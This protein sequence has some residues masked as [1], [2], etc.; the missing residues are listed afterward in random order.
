MAQIQESENG[1]IS[2]QT[3]AVNE[4]EI[5]IKC[6]LVDVWT[7]ADYSSSVSAFSANIFSAVETL[8]RKLLQKEPNPSLNRIVRN[9]AIFFNQTPL[10]VADLTEDQDQFLQEVGE[11]SNKIGTGST[12][13]AY[14]LHK[15]YQ[16]EMSALSNDEMRNHSSSFTKLAILISDGHSERDAALTAA[17]ILKSSGFNIL[18]LIVRAK[19]GGKT[20]EELDSEANP[21]V[22]LMKEISG[23][24]SDY[25]NSLEDAFFA[26]VT[27]QGLDE[28]FRTK[29]TCL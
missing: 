29:F 16:A 1:E 5:W 25:A 26:S 8:G 24:T 17:R 3:G 14:A 21:G 22:K 15:V 19:E 20:L 10:V 18:S 11:H 7:V 28:F 2:I 27:L 6:A 4:S 13:I 9:G 23:S 12:S